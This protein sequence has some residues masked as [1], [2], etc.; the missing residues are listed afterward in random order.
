MGKYQNIQYRCNYIAENIESPWSNAQLNC[1][2]NCENCDEKHS[3]ESNEQ[4]IPG[5]F[6]I[7]LVSV[8]H[9]L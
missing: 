7:T 1:I 2:L 9:I 5:K 4:L 8:S 6:V 3:V